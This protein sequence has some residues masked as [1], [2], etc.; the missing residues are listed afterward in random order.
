MIKSREKVNYVVQRNVT[1]E[2]GKFYDIVIAHVGDGQN[3]A[4][5]L[6]VTWQNRKGELEESTTEIPPA[7]LRLPRKSKCL[8]VD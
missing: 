5:Q 3:T 4:F 2:F 6:G 7:L 8:Q 1:L